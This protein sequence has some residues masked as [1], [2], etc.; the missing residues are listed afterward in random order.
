MPNAG[1]CRESKEEKRGKKESSGE[2][3]GTGGRRSRTIGL[4][5]DCIM[6]L[7]SSQATGRDKICGAGMELCN[8]EMVLL[9]Y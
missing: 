4:D 7:C 8:M 9:L 3:D 2:R 5:S 6:T 1:L